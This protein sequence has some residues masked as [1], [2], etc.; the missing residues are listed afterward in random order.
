MAGRHDH[1][2]VRRHAVRTARAVR[3]PVREVR[4]LHEH[5]LA[6]LR[7]VE[8]D[9]VDVF[10]DV[11]DLRRR[12]RASRVVVPSCLMSM[13]FHDFGP[14][15]THTL[16]SSRAVHE[17][18]RGRALPRFELGLRARVGPRL[19]PALLVVAAVRRRDDGLDRQ[20]RDQRRLPPGTAP[21]RSS[22]PS[23]PGASRSGTVATSFRSGC[24]AAM[25]SVSA[26]NS[27][28]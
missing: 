12:D 25:R 5:R 26:V 1:H 24:F 11:G 15:A 9:R 6:D 16:S 8:R 21:R 19:A 14:D 28:R 17:P 22:S 23:A 10:V 13:C 18:R 2:E 20:A 3:L 27:I 7:H 4:R